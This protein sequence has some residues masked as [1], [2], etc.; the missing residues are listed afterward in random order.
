MLNNR[1]I[2]STS[3]AFFLKIRSRVESKDAIKNFGWLFLDKGIRAIL[4]LLVG[5]WVA[6]YL[7]PNQF[8][9]LSYYLA[10]IAIFQSITTLGMDGIVVRE[11]AKAPANTSAILGTVFLLR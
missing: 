3:L 1:L 9:E 6:R 7:G 8:G 5:A 2:K 11:I 4:G 10:L